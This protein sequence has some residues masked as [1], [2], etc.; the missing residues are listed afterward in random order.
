MSEQ[1]FYKVL[2]QYLNAYL[3]YLKSKIRLILIL[4]ISFG[5][6][7]LMYSYFKTLKY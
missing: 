3:G 5:V 4:G 2:Y 7:G 6:L 1:S